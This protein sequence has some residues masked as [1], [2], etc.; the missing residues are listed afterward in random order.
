MYKKLDLVILCGGRGSRLKN[1]TKKLPKPLIKI[2]NKYF[3]TYLIQ[4]YQRYDFENIYL[5]AGFKGKIIQKEFNNKKFNFIKTKCFIENRPLGTGGSLNLLKKKLKNDFLL[6]NGDSYLEYNF[7]NFLKKSNKNSLCNIILINSK[8]YKEN[9]QLNNLSINKSKQ[10][11]FKSKFN[12]MNSGIYLFKKKILK[13]IPK[14]K[15]SLE[16]DLLTSLISKKQVSGHIENGFFIDIGTKKRLNYARKILPKQL[17]RPAVF[18]DR[19]GVL[20]E[21]TGY[22]YKWKDF[23]FKKNIIKKLLHFIKKKYLIFIV[24]NQSGIGRKFYKIR[25]FDFLHKKIKTYLSKK[26]IYLDDVLYCP[27]HPEYGI[28]K[29]KNNCL[30]RKPNNLLIKN[31]FKNWSINK[32]KSF[33]IGDKFTDKICA[34]LSRLKF[35]Y[36]SSNLKIDLDLF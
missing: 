9:N 2:N 26:G 35:F 32:N 31:I 17:K 22:V 13:Q 1:L 7:E 12:L 10:V 6:I 5:L 24:T 34:D 4:F 16:N 29:F 14:K 36:Y 21:D 3:L 27:H 15:F 20:N 28:G 18:L 19:D 25:D 23:I 30:C 8:N 11:L 33:M